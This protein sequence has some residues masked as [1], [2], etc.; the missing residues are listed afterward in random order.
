M[1]FSVQKI[2]NYSQDFY[3]RYSD[4]TFISL[5]MIKGFNVDINENNVKGQ[6]FY[7]RIMYHSLIMV[8]LQIQ[9]VLCLWLWNSSEPRLHRMI[10]NWVIGLKIPPLMAVT[11]SLQGT[12]LSMSPFLF[13][14]YQV[15]FYNRNLARMLTPMKL[16]SNSDDESHPDYDPIIVGRVREELR[17][18]IFIT[19]LYLKV[20]PELA[21]FLIAFG[22]F[23]N[24]IQS[25]HDLLDPLSIIPIVSWS[26]QYALV[27]TGIFW[28]QSASLLTMV[29]FSDSIY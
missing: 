16:V 10:G 23:L 6:N 25:Y 11:P 1:R 2:K 8:T 28:C 12:F 24:N 27:G 7:R 14:S 20:F 26:V 13:M 3:Q 21:G 22:S 15:L 18:L 9:S 29:I 4:P 17:P 5:L 19:R